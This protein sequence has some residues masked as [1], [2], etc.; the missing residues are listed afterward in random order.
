METGAASH[1]SRSLPQ[2]GLDRV[3]QEKSNPEVNLYVTVNPFGILVDEG[4]NNVQDELECNDKPILSHSSHSKSRESAPAGMGK[5]DHGRSVYSISRDV[6]A[7]GG[8]Q[9][10]AS[11]QAGLADCD[12]EKVKKNRYLHHSN[13]NCIAE[14]VNKACGD[15]ATRTENFSKGFSTRKSMQKPLLLLLYIALLLGKGSL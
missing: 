3:E 4:L 1:S 5:T 6:T 2:S 9:D 12:H 10:V 8:A 14:G 15:K 13:V 11:R 7:S